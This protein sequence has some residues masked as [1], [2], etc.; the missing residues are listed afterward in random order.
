MAY[1]RV[2]WSAENRLQSSIF[3]PLSITEYH[4]GWGSGW[5]KSIAVGVTAGTMRGHGWR[6]EGG[7]GGSCLDARPRARVSIGSE[8]ARPRLLGRQFCRRNACQATQTRSATFTLVSG[9]LML[10]LVSI[11]KSFS[12]SAKVFKIRSLGASLA[13]L[14]RFRRCEMV[15]SPS[16]LKNRSTMLLASASEVTSI[17]AV[18]PLRARGVDSL[19]GP[20]LSQ[21][22]PVVLAGHPANRSRSA[23]LFR[24]AAEP[25]ILTVWTPEMSLGRRSFPYSRKMVLCVPDPTPSPPQ[26]TRLAA[27]VS[28]LR[29]GDITQV[30]AVVVRRAGAGPDQGACG[31]ARLS[32]DDGIADEG[33]HREGR[34]QQLL[35]CCT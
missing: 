6:G 5:G 13:R 35:H 22:L 16:R 31:R 30:L 3:R 34:Q 9:S 27:A 28:P 17:A 33:E 2:L 1:H 8:E 25:S 10:P 18:S 4:L 23:M 12:R 11:R 26:T 24:V 15:V 14:G 20:T 21:S 19:S 29:D 7:G 32:L